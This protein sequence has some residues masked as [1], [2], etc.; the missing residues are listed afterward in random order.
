MTS[1]S[2]P[3]PDR[4]SPTSIETAI[5]N[6]RSRRSFAGTPLDRA[7]VG[8]LLWAAQGVTRDGM[9]DAYRAAP[10]A[11]ATY[12]LVVFLELL[13]D[14][15]ENLPAG[16]LRYE[17]AEHGLGQVQDSPL[18]DDLVRAA[19]GQDVVEGGAATIVL[20]ADFDRTT[21]EYPDHGRRYVHMEAGH[22]AQNVQ[23]ACESRGL[24]CCPVGAFQDEQLHSALS[25]PDELDPLYL[26][27]VGNRIEGDE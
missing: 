24:S 2:L 20:A 3:V 21:R 13:P 11:G 16:L 6:R 23:L 7:D 27:P 18:R 26:L 10:S 1:I 15:C 25:L 14:S 4:D 8:Q 5:A 9:G 17:P 22:A 12:P 19:L